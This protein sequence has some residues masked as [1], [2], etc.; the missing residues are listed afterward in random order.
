M[1]TFLRAKMDQWWAVQRQRYLDEFFESHP[2]AAITE[3]IYNDP[4]GRFMDWAEENILGP[5]EKA[6]GREKAKKERI[7]LE[8]E[9]EER[10][11]PFMFIQRPYDAH[12]GDGRP[13][14]VFVNAG[15][16]SGLTEEGFEVALG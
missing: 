6:L 16:F 1:V 15:S 13:S 8:H 3:V 12:L 2:S 4:A 14:T 9:V 7:K 10:L 11:M 5:L